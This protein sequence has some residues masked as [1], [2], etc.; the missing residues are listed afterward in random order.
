MGGYPKFKKKGF[1]KSYRT[2]NVRNTYKG[3]KYESIKIDL[4]KKV[5][6]LPKLKEIKVK[7]YRN[8]E[9]ID[10]RIINA[11]I[12]IDNTCINELN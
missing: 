5:I 7:G 8:L 6:T 3:K 9:R 10:E 11:T 2:N 4:E 12:S 1:K